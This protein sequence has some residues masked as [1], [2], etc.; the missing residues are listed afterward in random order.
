MAKIALYGLDIIPTL[1]GGYGVAVSQIVDS[2][3][4][5]TNGGSHPL[6]IVIDGVGGERAPKLIGEHKTAVFPSRSGPQLPLCLAAFLP[7]QDLHYENCRRDLPP[8][9]VFG[10]GQLV[11]AFAVRTLR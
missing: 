7:V 11:Y 1:D 5:T 6:E 2:G 4:R 8:L 3:V 9:A 10:G